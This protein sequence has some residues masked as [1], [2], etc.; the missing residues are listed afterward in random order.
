MKNEYYDI[1]PNFI[2]RTPL[3]PFS[4]FNTKKEMMDSR[5]FEEAIYLASP[6][7]YDELERQAGEKNEHLRLSLHKYYSRACSRCTPFGIFAGCSIGKFEKEWSSRLLPA[8][9][10][11]AYARLDM[12]YLSSLISFL[13][14][15]PMVKE[16]L[17]FHINDSIYKIGHSYRY[18]E[19]ISNSRQHRIVEVEATD[20]LNKI[21]VA[22]SENK[23]IETLAKFI[24]NE[25]IAIEEAKEYINELIK[26]Q[27]LKSELEMH[28]T[29]ERDPF[30]GLLNRM[31]TLLINIPVMKHLTEIWSTFQKINVTPIGERILYYKQIA[32]IAQKIEVPFVLKNLIQVDLYK[33]HEINA[34]FAYKKDIEEG[35][36]FLNKIASYYT[37]PLL[38]RFKSDFL[39]RYEYREVPLLEVLD[40]DYG[41]NYYNNSAHVTNPLVYDIFMLNNNLQ[42]SYVISPW[43][44][45]LL[46][47][48]INTFKT[49]MDE[50][51]LDDSDVKEKSAYWG[52]LPATFSIFASIVKGGKENRRIF[53][54]SVGASSALN[55]IS[56]FCYTDQQIFKHAQEIADKEQ[57]IYSDKIVAEIIHL[58]SERVAN[59]VLRPVLRK[60]EMHYLARASAD[61][62]IPLS[63]IML[64]IV[65]NSFV[66][67]SKKHNKEIIP[68]LSTAHN[69][70]GNGIPVYRFLCDL[71]YQNKRGSLNFQW[72]TLSY[73]F[74]YLPRV[75]YHNC[76]L[77]KQQWKIGVEDIKDWKKLKS[78]ALK[79]EIEYFCIK[80]R[81]PQYVVISM[82]D[83]DLLI[84]FNNMDSINIFM[85]TVE[86]YKVI[87][88][89][90][91]L[92]DDSQAVIESDE[93]AFC[94]EFIFSFYRK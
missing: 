66:L 79:K 38:E 71:Q 11:I 17:T 74:D 19:Y 27:I 65:N 75:R 39:Q 15:L 61:E 5:L 82:S 54:K 24:T 78:E 48:Y 41:I 25:D 91:F 77:A 34:A 73:L 9:E 57:E 7:L 81:L 47:K 45:K 28:V 1:F 62:P 23:D 76:I 89:K 69:Y 4:Y 14:S 92:F 30:E 21:I 35:V 52:D 12:E 70:A 31:R 63:D 60:F 10:Q 33:P 40:T 50:L 37:N 55:L 90:E 32:Q 86:A 72:G 56:R 2:I 44:Q 3:F 26:A 80:K 51:V 49:E 18:V 6:D 29:G 16:K 43:E 13:E 59:V 94:N 53:L 36:V 88:I 42:Q 8:K 22:A 58:P 87:I 46:L 93:G 84:D 85:K 64:S 83:N 20:Y 68:F 67:R